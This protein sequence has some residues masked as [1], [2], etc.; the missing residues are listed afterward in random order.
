LA[1]CVAVSISSRGT[2][3][4]E[5]D[6]SSQVDPGRLIVLLEAFRSGTIILSILLFKIVKELTGRTIKYP[7][8][9]IMR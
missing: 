6:G 7:D 3:I 8:F 9:S 1:G 4:A 2:G 5:N